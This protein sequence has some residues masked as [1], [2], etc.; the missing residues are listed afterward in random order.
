MTAKI[1]KW[2]FAGVMVLGP[3]AAGATNVKTAI[4]PQPAAPV[5]VT[6]C[7]AQINDSDVG[8]TRY[9]LDVDAVYHNGSTKRAMTVRLRFDLFNDFDESTGDEFGI[10]R[11]A[12]DPGADSNTLLPDVKRPAGAAYYPTWESINLHDTTTELIC[13]VDTV[14]F[15]DGTQWHE[16]REETPAQ[17]KRLLANGRTEPYSIITMD[18]WNNRGG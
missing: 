1:T 8:N 7:S 11:D 5:Q 10:E 15:D 4:R 17:A 13:S 12:V 9:W 14:K 2:V 3:V 18:D 6:T 16:T